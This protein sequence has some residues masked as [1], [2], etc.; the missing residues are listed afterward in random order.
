MEI[1][2]EGSSMLSNDMLVVADR[3]SFV[4]R[5]SCVFRELNWT[6]L[7]E[8]QFPVQDLLKIVVDGGKHGGL[9][10]I[11]SSGGWVFFE[12][13]AGVKCTAKLWI[14][15]EAEASRSLM[16]IRKRVGESNEPWGMPAFIGRDLKS[17]PSAMNLV[18]RWL[19]KLEIQLQRSGLS[20]G[21]HLRGRHAKPRRMR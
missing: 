2:E 10:G 17:E 9:V 15:F 13:V 14:G 8:S 1:V 6:R 11:D 18:E 20:K 19:R 12:G 4:N 21:A 5:V 7:V 16:C 3:V